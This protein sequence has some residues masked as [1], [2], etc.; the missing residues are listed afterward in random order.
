MLRW[1]VL[2]PKFIIMN[3]SR[4][5]TAFLS[6]QTSSVQINKNLGEFELTELI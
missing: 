6:L 5:D 4:L 2:Y 1:W 3:F